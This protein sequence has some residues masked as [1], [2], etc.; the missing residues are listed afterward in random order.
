MSVSI[1]RLGRFRAEAARGM[2][3]CVIV[4]DPHIVETGESGGGLA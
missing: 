4:D 3:G 1:R 2:G